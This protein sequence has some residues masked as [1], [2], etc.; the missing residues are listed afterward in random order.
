MT[1]ENDKAQKPHQEK[2]APPAKDDNPVPTA[3][4]GEQ[5]VY[6][7][8]EEELIKKRLEDLGYI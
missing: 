8:E 6:S 7:D 3:P 1:M 5:P 2:Q 4:G